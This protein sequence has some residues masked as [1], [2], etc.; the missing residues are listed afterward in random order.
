MPPFSP[1]QT[2]NISINIEELIQI[3][4]NLTNIKIIDISFDKSV[5]Q[6][7]LGDD[8]AT[9]ATK[10]ITVNCSIDYEYITDPPILADLGT[11]KLEVD[12]LTFTVSGSTR[13]TSEGYFAINL[14]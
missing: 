14:S 3:S 13:I 6:V 5:R 11:I 7:T 10:N 4:A 9:F 1:N 12:N 2:Q 8:T